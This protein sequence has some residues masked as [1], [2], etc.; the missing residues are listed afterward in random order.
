MTTVTIII[1]TSCALASFMDAICFGKVYGDPL[2]EMWHLAKALC[3]GI[4]YGYLIWTNTDSY[5]AFAL[6]SLGFIL[7]LMV[8]HEFLYAL[9]RYL[10]VYKLDTKIDIP[11]LEKVWARWFHFGK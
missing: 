1:C 3:L 2:Q 8:Q 6:W 9:F 7:W 5:P 10:N 11:I 4:P